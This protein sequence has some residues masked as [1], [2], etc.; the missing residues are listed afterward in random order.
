MMSKSKYCIP[1]SEWEIQQQRKKRSSLFWSLSYNGIR[2]RSSFWCLPCQKALSIL[3]VKMWGFF[4][5]GDGGILSVTITCFA[6]WWH[7]LPLLSTDLGGRGAVRIPCHSDFC[8][9][10]KAFSVGPLKWVLSCHPL[11]ASVKA[12]RKVR[13]GDKW[14]LGSYRWNVS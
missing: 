6:S 4:W 8:W 9:I 11:V 2:N 7:H 10:R 12:P 1:F 14:E 5:C 13:R 3:G